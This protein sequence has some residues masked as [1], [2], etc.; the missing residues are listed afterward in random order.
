MASIMRFALL[1][2]VSLSLGACAS[3]ND[4]RFPSLAIRPGERVTGTAE[5]APPAIPAA[6]VQ[7][8]T[9][10]AALR[11]SA[12]AAH[13]RFMGRRSNAAALASAA[14]GSAVASEAWSVAQVALADLESARSQAMIALADLDALYVAESVAAVPTRTSGDLE[15][16]AAVRSEVT[17]WIGEEDAVLSSLRGRLAG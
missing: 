11:S 2:A 1:L 14:A 7:S 16:T 15:A 6:T 10:L 5:P 17:S 8:G 13:Q 3:N 12:L 4:A 9:K